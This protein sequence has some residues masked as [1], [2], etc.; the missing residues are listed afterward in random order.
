VYV[1]CL[2]IDDQSQ[3]DY[4]S[5][6]AVKFVMYDDYSREMNEVDVDG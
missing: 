2:L 3:F 4:D 5:I 1:P 6:A